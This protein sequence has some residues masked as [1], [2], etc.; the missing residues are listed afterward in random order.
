MAV[1]VLEAMG[2]EMEKKGKSVI[3]VPKE[4]KIPKADVPAD[5]SACHTSP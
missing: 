1:T 2:T 3:T 4:R 5:H